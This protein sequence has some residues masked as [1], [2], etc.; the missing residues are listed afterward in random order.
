MT[1]VV[2]AKLTATETNG[3]YSVFEVTAPPGGGP[4]LLHTHAP[5]ETFYILEGCFAFGGLGP[6]GPYRIQATTGAVVHIPAG[7]LHGFQNVGNTPGRV[8][9]VYE[10]PGQ[11]QAFFAAMHAAVDHPDP[12][13]APLE[14]LPNEAQI[15]AIFA[16]HAMEI[17]S[18]DGIGEA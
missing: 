18:P 15:G 9:I 2:E 6:E 14:A 16:Q 10:P 1:E 3:A 13:H 8:L 17:W 4:A 12:L 11:M 5:Q 7:K